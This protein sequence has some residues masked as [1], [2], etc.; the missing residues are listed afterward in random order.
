MVVVVVG[1]VVV[2]V[3]SGVAVVDLSGSGNQALVGGADAG[4]PV[5]TPSKQCT[6]HVLNNKPQ[7]LHEH[8]FCFCI[9]Q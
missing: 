6:N 3:V 8:F 7:P 1:A 9:L 5:D 4:P 2:V